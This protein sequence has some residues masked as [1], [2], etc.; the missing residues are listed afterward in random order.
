MTEGV[1]PV[2]DDER[3][4][5]LLREGA[6][7]GMVALL[8]AH[9]G[10]ARNYVRKRYA[11][12]LDE[13]QIEDAL[14]DAAFRLVDT[15]DPAKGKPLGGWLLFLADRQ[16]IDILR[17]EQRHHRQR[18]E[19]ADGDLVRGSE[20]PTQELLDSEF[21]ARVRHIMATHLSDLERKVMTADIDEGGAVNAKQLAERLGTDPRSI[22]TARLRAR[23]KLAKHLENDVSC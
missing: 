1:L 23:R 3:I 15:Y 6:E 19:W 21:A 5:A 10:R 8:Q 2:P 11:T 14:A 7:E 9:G 4:L 12:V 22:Y 20:S 16:A 17:R 13:H 18:V